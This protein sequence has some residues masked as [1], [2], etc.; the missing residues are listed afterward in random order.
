VDQGLIWS[1]G[2]LE[3]GGLVGL[4]AAFAIVAVVAVWWYRHAGGHCS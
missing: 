2:W 4:T 1:A 3:L